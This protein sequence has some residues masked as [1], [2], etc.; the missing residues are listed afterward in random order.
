MITKK[1]HN[2]RVALISFVLLMIGVVASA[3]MANLASANFEVVRTMPHLSEMH[4]EFMIYGWLSII[5]SLSFLILGAILSIVGTDNMIFDDYDDSRQ[6]ELEEQSY[7][8]THD[9][10]E[11]S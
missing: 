1:Q 10:L 4:T 9:N 2:I 8:E 6:V 7:Q 11:Q 3:L 5:L